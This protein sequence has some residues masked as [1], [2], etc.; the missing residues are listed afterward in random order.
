MGREMSERSRVVTAA[1]VGAAI[2]GIW[3]WLYLTGKGGRVR[4]QIEPTIDRFVAALDQVLAAGD[5][6][7]DAIDEGRRLLARSTAA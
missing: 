1:C 2:G 7:K 4:D 3:G 6:T 5:K